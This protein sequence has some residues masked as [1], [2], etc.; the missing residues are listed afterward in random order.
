[1]TPDKRTIFILNESEILK[2]IMINFE[3]SIKKDL[4]IESRPV[5]GGWKNENMTS[6]SCCWDSAIT[7]FGPA[8]SVHLVKEDIVQLKPIG[9]FNNGFIICS[10][11]TNNIVELFA[12]DQHAA[13]ERIR[14]EEIAAKY[15]ISC[16][17]L[18]QPI[19]LKVSAEDEDFVLLKIESFREAGFLIRQL[20]DTFLLDAL[21]AFHGYDSSIEGELYILQRFNRF[22]RFL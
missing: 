16:Q 6:E 18:V 3:N 4:I 5:D 1:V 11:L 20:D 10:K 2:N 7:S 9:Q 21:P 14:Y 12:V 22:C 8:N 13:D 17:K 15:T 19:K